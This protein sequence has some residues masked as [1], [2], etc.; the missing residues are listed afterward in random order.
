MRTVL[1][2]LGWLAAFGTRPARLVALTGLTDAAGTGIAAACLP[3]YLIRGAHFSALEVALALTVTGAAELA[4]AVP[5]G[6]LARRFGVR[7]YLI[8]NKSAQAVLWVALGLVTQLPVVIAVL[9]LIGYSRGGLGGLSQ[10][11]TAAAVGTR[12]RS[13]ILGAVRSLRNIGYLVAGGVVA[14][15]L[16]VGGTGTLTAALVLNAAS[17]AIGA[18]CAWQ[19]RVEARPAREE[20]AP[21]SGA[22]LRD[23][24]YLCLIPLAAV[25]ATTAMVLDVGLPLWVLRHHR[26]PAAIVGVVL[27]INTAIV[28]VAQ[29]QVA[30]RLDTVRAAVRGMWV[31]A[32]A[33]LVAAVCIGVTAHLGTGLSALLLVVAALALTAAEL[34]ESPSWWTLSFELAPVARRDEYL[35]TF[36]VSSSLVAL[37]GP[38]AMTLIV[39]AGP[40]GWVAYGVVA[41][42][43]AGLTSLAVRP[44]VAIAEPSEA[45]G[46]VA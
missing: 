18:F 12:R 20:S 44:R 14:A 46:A 36:D 24:G 40:G 35:A 16:S 45:E 4:G 37:V 41:L 15:L 2:R 31:S 23:P 30:R 3:F 1:D 6:M 28:I 29:F 7:R 8:V 42:L 9:L 22:V 39:A 34:W 33:L 13:E 32:A 11:F 26:I 19:I 21:R 10:S 43:A 27:V 5:N 38:A 25:F 17:Y